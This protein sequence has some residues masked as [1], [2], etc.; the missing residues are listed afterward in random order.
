MSLTESE[1]K[2]TQL[3]QCQNELNQLANHYRKEYLKH[4]DGD[5][6][7]LVS[8][9]DNHYYMVPIPLE[10]EFYQWVQIPEVMAYKYE[11][12]DWNDYRVNGPHTIVIQEW[13]EE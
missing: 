8:D 13:Y 4:S 7:R 10:E 9:D 11:G 12:P 3:K 6:Y 5:G 1:L 2:N